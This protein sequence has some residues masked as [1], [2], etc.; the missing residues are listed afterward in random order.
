MKTLANNTHKTV[1]SAYE[2]ARLEQ[3]ETLVAML[4]HFYIHLGMGEAHAYRSALADFETDYPDE[5][6]AFRSALS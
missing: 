4:T 3:A 2:E 5:V 1:V 6:A